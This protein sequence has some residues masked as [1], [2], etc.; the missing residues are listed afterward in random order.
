MYILQIKNPEA[1]NE[2]VTLLKLL[3]LVKEHDSRSTVSIYT[4]FLK[5][6][7]LHMSENV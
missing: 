3:V 5:T 4:Y 7:E 6:V 1:W 2:A